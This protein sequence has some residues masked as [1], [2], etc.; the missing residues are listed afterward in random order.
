MDDLGGFP[1]IFGNTHLSNEQ[2]LANANG[3]PAAKLFWDYEYL[4]GN[5]NSFFIFF[6]G[7]FDWTKKNIWIFFGAQQKLGGGF[8]YFLFSSLFGEDDPIWLIFFRWVGSTTN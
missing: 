2:K 8:K 1:T 3:W 7:P 6:H 4:V 5:M